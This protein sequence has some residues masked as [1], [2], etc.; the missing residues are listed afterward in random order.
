MVENRHFWSKIISFWSKLGIKNRIVY[1]KIFELRWKIVI[2]GKIISHKKMPLVLLPVMLIPLA[3]KITEIN[4]IENVKSKETKN[5]SILIT[6]L[7]RLFSRQIQTHRKITPD[8]E[9][10]G[11]FMIDQIQLHHHHQ[12][13]SHPNYHTLPHQPTTPN[14]HTNKHHQLTS[15]IEHVNLT[16]PSNLLHWLIT[17]TTLTYY[18]DPLH[19]PTTLTYYTRLT[20]TFSASECFTTMDKYKTNPQHLG[21]FPICTHVCNVQSTAN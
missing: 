2:F 3:R 4:V 5:F 21:Y 9:S 11:M 14:H 6:K 13:V 7:W 1:L 19:W 17:P 15:P 20:W 10:N 8:L 16:N 18:T 12:T